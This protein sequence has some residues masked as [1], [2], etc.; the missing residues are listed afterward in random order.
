MEWPNTAVAAV[1]IR[2]D[3]SGHVAIGEG[4]M[5]GYLPAPRLG[6]GEILLQ[7]RGAESRISI[8]KNTATN[9]NISIVA[10]KSITIGDDCLIGELVTIVDCDFHE[11]NPI[12]R[13]HSAGEIAP[14]VIGNNAWLGSRV[15]VLK[16][17]TIGDN[18]VV[19]AGSVVTKSLS[20]NVIAAGIPAIVVRQIGA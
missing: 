6:S 19:A 16:G 12:S 10:M 13:K 1:P 17:V 15:M 20:A 14:V 4:V 7:A 8:G 9:N 11:I 5:L 3:G 18:T 2:V